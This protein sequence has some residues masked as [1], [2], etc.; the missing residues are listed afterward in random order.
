MIANKDIHLEIETMEKVRDSLKDD[1]QK[2]ILK[3]AIIQVR[4]LHNV[5]TNQIIDMKARGVEIPSVKK[6][7]KETE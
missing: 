4:L 3:A 2:A 1:Y 6:N 7:T 5:R